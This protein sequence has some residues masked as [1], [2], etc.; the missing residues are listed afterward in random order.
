MRV[1]AVRVLEKL[2]QL[3]QKLGACGG[4]AYMYI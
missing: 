4:A 1:L 2:R 3:L